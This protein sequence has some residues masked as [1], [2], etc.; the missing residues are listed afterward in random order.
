MFSEGFWWHLRN[1]HEQSCV[2]WNI[3][4]R[5]NNLMIRPCQRQGR[6]SQKHFPVIW[7]LLIW[8]F[9][10]GGIFTWRQSPDYSV[11]LWKD[12][13]LRLL[14]KSFQIKC[15]VQFPSFQVNIRN[16]GLNL[17][18]AF[19][20]LCLWEWGFHAVPLFFFNIFGDLHFD[21]LIL[22]LC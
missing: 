9:C 6:G 18:N 10:H 5:H 7:T 19:C 16:R 1:H 3:L 12:L 20:T 2:I 21:A 15:H 8:N 4:I 17:K 13:S 11:E 22:G 14:V